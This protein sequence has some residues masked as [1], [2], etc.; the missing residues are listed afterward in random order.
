MK[1]EIHIFFIKQNERNW[2]ELF[3][4]ERQNKV[5]VHYINDYIKINR[6]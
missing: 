1:V 2:V 5:S 3:E 4:T 6:N